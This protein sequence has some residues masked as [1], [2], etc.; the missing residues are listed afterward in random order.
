LWPDWLRCVL[1]GIAMV[2]MFLGVAIVAD[3][4]VAAIDAVTSRRRQRKKDNHLVTEKVWNDTVA[5]LSLMALGSSAPE[6]ALSVVD[7][8]KKQFFY[9]PLGAQTIA[10]SAAFNLLVIVAVCVCVI[11]SAEVR[12]IKE[13]P[14]FYVTAAVSVFAYLWLAFILVLHTPNVVDTWEAIAT[15]LYLPVFIW[16]SYKVDIGDVHRFLAR[17]KLGSQVPPEE[18]NNAAISR[19]LAWDR[20]TVSIQA[21]PEPQELEIGVSR[22]AGAIGVVSFLCH[23]ERL[24]AVPDF[25][26]V[27]LPEQKIELSE[28]VVKE[29]ITLK[30][31]PKASNRV[32]RKFL[33]I[34]DNAKG[35]IEFDAERDGG[36]AASF[37]TVTIT[38][39]A[40]LGGW[41]CMRWLDACLNINAIHAG[42]QAWVD[43]FTSICSVSGE[44]EEGTTTLDWVSYLVALPWKLLFSIVP[45]TN[46]F[47]GWACFF[48]ALAGI[49]A[50]TIVISDLAELFGCVLG[51]TDDVTAIIFVALGTS[52]PDLFAS[53]SAAKEDET[54]DASIVNVTG[55]NSVNVFLG[56]GLPWTIGAIYWALKTNTAEWE[57]RYPEHRRVE[58]GAAFVVESRNLGFCVL[59][60]G[61]ACIVALFLLFLRRH[62]LGAEL[63]GPFVPKVA[64]SAAFMLFWLGFIGISSWRVM[65]W[66]DANDMELWSVVA[67]IGCFEVVVSLLTVLVIVLYRVRADPSVPQKKEVP[68]AHVRTYSRSQSAQSLNSSNSKHSKGERASISSKPS[69][70]AKRDRRVSI[71]SK[72]SS[73]LTLGS[74]GG[75]SSCGLRVIKPRHATSRSSEAVRL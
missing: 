72:H 50:L 54:A 70:E 57:M 3:T 32:D 52:M 1:Y 40:T 48:G 59:V 8:F 60:F 74:A 9:T 64:T 66:R 21:G 42:N 36:R 2:Y 27:E 5:T 13:L 43:Q 37:L 20:E 51:I 65:R 69:S 38:S 73:T 29:S 49:G 4:F 30:I 12:K 71:G 56:L 46:Y 34:M 24:S 19:F 6:I 33:V 14:A 16:V 25:D 47:G 39:P 23:T 15:F 58:G 28:E 35:N 18:A 67:G 62:M 31:L 41:C 63:G 11:P 17:V 26:Y 55:S 22:P 45:P 68:E 7:L 10:G 44:D 53:L 61:A 75:S